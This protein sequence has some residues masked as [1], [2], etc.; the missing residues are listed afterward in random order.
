MKNVKP[1]LGAV[2]I[3]G[4]DNQGGKV[5]LPTEDRRV[6]S[7]VR[8]KTKWIKR[9]VNAMK[10]KFTR[11][12]KR[13]AVSINHN[14]SKEICAEYQGRVHEKILIAQETWRKERRKK[15]GLKF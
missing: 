8:K 3:V 1:M 6:I 5:I 11:N 13:V 12:K 10:E 9:F 7:S 14:R 4:K 2:M 15:M